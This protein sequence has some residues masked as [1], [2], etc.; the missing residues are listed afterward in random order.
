MPAQIL[1]TTMIRMIWW[2]G[3]MAPRWRPWPLG[4]LP[5]AC[6]CWTSGCLQLWPMVGVAVAGT[7]DPK[8]LTCRDLPHLH[9]ENSSPM[10]RQFWEPDL[11]PIP[12]RPRRGAVWCHWK[13]F[14]G[15]WRNRIESALVRGCQDSGSHRVLIP[16][17]N[18]KVPW[19]FGGVSYVGR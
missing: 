3:C 1:M 6:K 12:C 13:T 11:S 5:G 8:A 14:L 7:G 2:T 9:C 16:W 19:Q 10:K 18:P 17:K 4:C 15:L